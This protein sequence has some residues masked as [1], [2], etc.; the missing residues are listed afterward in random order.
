MTISAADAGVPSLQSTNN[1]AVT[2]NVIRN[3]NPPRFTN[4]PFTLRPGIVENLNP[5]SSVYRAN[6]VDSDNVR[7]DLYMLPAI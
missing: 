6:A 4:L 1:A 7:I 3:Q 2:V 5:G